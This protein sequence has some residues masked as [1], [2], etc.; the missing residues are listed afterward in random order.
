MAIR[1]GGHFLKTRRQAVGQAI[2]LLVVL[3][4]LLVWRC[5]TEE[6]ML[7]V[8]M[9]ALSSTPFTIAYRAWRF[10]REQERHHIEPTPEM[11]FGFHVLAGIPL[12]LGALLFIVLV[13]L[14]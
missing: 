9:V 5:R 7:A 12:Q 14:S 13:E 3:L 11:T 1:Y 6:P 10:L 4:P 2:V 8:A